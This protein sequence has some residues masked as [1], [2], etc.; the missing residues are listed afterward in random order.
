[1]E[2][3][4]CRG[5]PPRAPPCGRP[6]RAPARGRTAGR[7]ARRHPGRPP[8]P[9]GAGRGGAPGGPRRAQISS[10][11]VAALAADGFPYRHIARAF[12]VSPS[13]AWA[14]A[15]RDTEQGHQGCSSEALAATPARSRP[16][17]TAR[18]PAA[19]T[20][21]QETSV[22]PDEEFA[23]WAQACFGSTRRAWRSC[24][25]PPILSENGL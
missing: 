24:W 18:P 25:M 9:H 8:H 16:W 7:L 1:M 15:Q 19:P 3:R 10:V 21:R 12:R 22:A 11:L 20:A 13:T 23:A 5:D 2:G 17:E 14:W 6:L 4:R